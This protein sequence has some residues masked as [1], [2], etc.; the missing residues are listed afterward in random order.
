[1]ALVVG[2]P[3]PEFSLRDQHGQEQSLAA[4]LGRR[5]VLVVFYPFAFTGVCTGELKALNAHAAAWDSL[6]A[7]VL[8]VSCD[9]LASLRAFADREALEIPLLSDFWPHGEVSTAYGAFEPLLGAAGRA[10]FVIDRQGLVRWTTRTAIADA[11]DVTG[12]LTALAEI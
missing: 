11:R 4:R 3:A 10:S 7:D 5:N 9:P 8:A 6:G 2:D 12:Y 1:V